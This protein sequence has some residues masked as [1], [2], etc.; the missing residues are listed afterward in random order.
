MESF[1]SAA[2]KVTPDFA[3]AVDLSGTGNQISAELKIGH[4]YTLYVGSA[5]VRVNIGSASVSAAS[6]PVLGAYTAHSFNLDADSYVAVIHE[7]GSTAHVAH[8]VP[9]SPGA[10][11][12]V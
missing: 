6:S 2:S 4:W 10:G 5:A 11:V 8:L 1:M 9:S 3:N 7:D 12:V